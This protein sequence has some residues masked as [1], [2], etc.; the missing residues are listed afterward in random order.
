MSLEDFLGDI[1]KSFVE[2]KQQEIYM[3]YVMIAAALIAVSY[4]FLWDPAEQGYNKTL[5]QTEQVEKKITEE[6]TSCVI[7][8]KTRSFN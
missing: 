1:D 8:L 7:T 2:K 6:K 4:L 5:S 3:T